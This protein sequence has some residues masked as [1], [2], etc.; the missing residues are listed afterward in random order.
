MTKLMHQPDLLPWL[1]R[2]QP[3]S[4]TPPIP[5]PNT[6]SRRCSNVTPLERLT[7]RANRLR[8]PLFIL[9]LSDRCLGVPGG[10]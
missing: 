10:A 1:P 4:Q 8:Y 5:K 7:Q 6:L 3:V 2:I 9:L